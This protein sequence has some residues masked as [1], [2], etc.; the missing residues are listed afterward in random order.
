MVH[1][2]K[3]PKDVCFDIESIFNQKKTQVKD[4]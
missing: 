3:S 2:K 1:I 4:Y